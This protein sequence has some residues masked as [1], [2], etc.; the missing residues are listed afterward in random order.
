MA[1]GAFNNPASPTINESIV[2]WCSN[3]IVFHLEKLLA[4]LEINGLDE[5]IGLNEQVLQVV[6]DAGQKG[7]SSRDIARKFRGFRNLDA[8]QKLEILTK[9]QANGH[10]VEKKEGQAVKYYFVFNVKNHCIDK[11]K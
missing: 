11:T 10:I 1:L 2:Q 6:H 8:V 7:I 9:L 4:R 5:E 3:W